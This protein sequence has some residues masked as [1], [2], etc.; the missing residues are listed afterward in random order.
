MTADKIQEQ[1]S[2]KAGRLRQSLLRFPPFFSLFLSLSLS[3]SFSCV[4][5]ID[6]VSP[7]RST[8]LPRVGSPDLFSLCRRKNQRFEASGFRRTA[9][10]SS[11]ARPH[12]VPRL[13]RGRE[14]S[15]GC[16]MAAVAGRRMK[17]TRPVPLSLSRAR[18][19]ARSLSVCVCVCVCRVCGVD[20][21]GLLP[22]IRAVC[23][24]HVLPH[25]PD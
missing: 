14:L 20:S 18:A 23:K 19:R 21:A 8:P 22:F 1:M 11:A 12:T 3:L 24:Q 13:D 7:P 15:G 16:E 9:A 5:S 6:C 2:T 10:F 17:K 25:P 4:G